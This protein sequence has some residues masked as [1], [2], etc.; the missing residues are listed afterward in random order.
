MLKIIAFAFIVITSLTGCVTKEIK[1]E[2]NDPPFTNL[3]P[4]AV[5]K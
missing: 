1:W 2:A 3:P 4:W 5:S